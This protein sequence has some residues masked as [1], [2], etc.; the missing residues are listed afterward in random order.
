MRTLYIFVKS[1]CGAKYYK[2]DK[3]NEIYSDK[4]IFENIKC[5]KRGES[6]PVVDVFRY[7]KTTHYIIYYNLLIIIDYI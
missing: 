5:E 6:R 4:W 1:M 2:I 3:C 7:I